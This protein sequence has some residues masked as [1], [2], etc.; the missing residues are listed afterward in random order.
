MAKPC[1]FSGRSQCVRTSAAPAGWTGR[2]LQSVIPVD[3]GVTAVTLAAE[4]APS[5]TWAFLSTAIGSTQN[6]KEAA[7]A[8]GKM[9]RSTH[10]L[11]DLALEGLDGGFLFALPREAAERLL[12]EAI[13][14]NV[15]AGSLI[16]RDDQ[17]PSLI[18]VIKGLLRVFLTS[19]DGRQ[20]TVRYA[21]SGDVAGLA[22]VIGGPAPMSIQAMTSSLVLALRVESLR[23]LLATDPGVARACAE[24]LTRQI[25]RLLA[26]ISERAFL[27]LR[28]RLA[29]ELLLLA[30]PGPG[31]DLVVHKSQQELADAIGSVRE[32]VTRNLHELHEEGLLDISRDEVTIRDPV[33]LADAAGEPDWRTS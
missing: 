20:L 26:D 15:P 27:P 22:L 16:Y 30:T 12:A 14:I 19:A 1:L 10:A 18:V 8:A 31:R 25:N 24:E 33:A 7:R 11:G 13:R 17:T 29:R 2:G 21:R 6:W 5:G 23:A 3:R 9:L 4:L 28:E 32:V